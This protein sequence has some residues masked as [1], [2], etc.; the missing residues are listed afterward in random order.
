MFLKR[1]MI[2]LSRFSFHDAL[3]EIEGAE[4]KATYKSMVRLTNKPFYLLD[5]LRYSDEDKYDKDNHKSLAVDEEW[6]H[7]GSRRGASFFHSFI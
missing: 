7:I 3:K 1:E 4:Q 5:L 2:Q 6:K